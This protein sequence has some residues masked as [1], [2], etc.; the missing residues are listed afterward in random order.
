MWGGVERVGWC[1]V[2]WGGVRCGGAGWD[3][4][5]C[6]TGSFAHV[7]HFVAYLGFATQCCNS[8]ALLSCSPTPCTPIVQL[9]HFIELQHCNPNGNSIILKSCNFENLSFTN[10]VFLFPFLALTRPEPDLTVE[11][12]TGMRTKEPCIAC[13]YERVGA[14][15]KIVTPSRDHERNMTKRGSATR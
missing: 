9:N 10:I 1:R 3:R 4:V 6:P 2:G 14:P 12:F 13:A 5:A 8:I 15:K 7:S 11:R